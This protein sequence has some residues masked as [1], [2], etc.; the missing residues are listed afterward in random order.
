MTSVQNSNDRRRAQHFWPTTWRLISYLKP[1]GWAILFAIIMAIGSVIMNIVSPKILGQATTIIYAGIVK[2]YREIHA[3]V[4]LH[5]LPIDFNAIA[6]IAVLVIV[7]YL[8]ASLLNF[9]ELT[10]MTWVSQRVV[11]NLRKQLKAK[12]ARVPVSFYDN[13]S[14]GELMSRMVND[15]DNIAGTLQTG[16]IQVITSTLT[17]FG[18]LILML[19]ISWKLTLLALITVPLSAAVVAFVAPAA[20][21]MFHQQQDELGKI[22]AQVEETYAGHTI[23]RTFNHEEDEEKRF[24]KKNKVYYN[25]AWRAQF[26]SSFIYPLM[27]FIRNLGY[28]MVAIAGAIGVIARTITIGNV[29]AFLQYTNMFSQPITQIANLAST[30][31]ITIASAERIFAVLDAKEMDDTLLPDHP[32]TGKNVPEIEFDHVDFSYKEDEPLIEDFNLKAP[33]KQTVAIVGPTGA[34]KTTIINLLERFYDAKGGHIYLAGHDTR[35]M[36]RHD[37]RTHIAMVLQDTWLFGGTVRENIRY[38]RNDATD[39][40][41][42]HAAKLAYADQF[43]RKLPAGY[44]TVLNEDASNISQGQRQLLTIAR[45]FLANPDVLILDEATSSVD[46]R[47]E[48]L[49]QQAMNDLQQNRT[50]F[51]VAHRLSTIRNAEQ[52][53]VLNH[54]HIIET[55]NHESLMAKNGFYADLYNSQFAGNNL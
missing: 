28:V 29:Q 8:V 50:S 33:A 52:I 47:T 20:Q 19:T 53:I 39:E 22:N 48:Q 18:V 3:G 26:L 27:N 2:G 37:L 36:T 11:Y 49:I 51:V 45:A 16:V 31:Q 15:M 1:W 25:V 40:E 23:V 21:R 6:K 54:G 44:D 46:T 55:G 34:G 42:E 10:I 7:L 35:S 14:N 5:T 9:I 24:D 32:K 41:V 12:M 43:I 4:H 30:I 38:G 17:F 13:H